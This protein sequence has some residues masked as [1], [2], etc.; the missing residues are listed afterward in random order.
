MSSTF[1]SWI[2]AARPKTLALAVAGPL[3]GISLALLK[4]GKVDILQAT[5]CILVAILL[6][7]LSNFS[8]DL[9]DFKKGTD[10]LA[11]RTDRALTS[12]AINESQMKTAI[13]IIT[14]ISIAVGITLIWFTDLSSSNQWI[15]FLIGL[16]AVAS[17]MAYTM[18]KRAYGYHGLGDLFVFIFFG[19]TSVMATYYIQTKTIQFEIVLAAI[20]IGSFSAMVLNINNVRDMKK[21]Q[22]NGK[23]TI[24]VKI[25]FR[26]SRVYHV[27]LAAIGSFCW[28]ALIMKFNLPLLAIPLFLFVLILHA[29]MNLNPDDFN[30]YNKQLKFTSLLTLLISVVLFFNALFYTLI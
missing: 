22:L 4:L 27:I 13:A 1:K 21:D 11:N 12:G 17:A 23:N 8:N 16:A 15:L 30:A 5:L 24:P 28:I 3:T 20:A 10:Q 26:N 29:F 14:L 6:Q 25:G 2:N 7:V 9:G 19:F 18:G